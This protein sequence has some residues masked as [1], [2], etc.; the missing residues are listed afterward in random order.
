MDSKEGRLADNIV[1]FARVLRRAGLPIGPAKVIDAIEAV[2][3]V[4]VERRDDFRYALAAVLVNRREQQEIFDQAFEVYWRDPYRVERMLQE[5]LQ[6]MGGLRRVERD[7][8]RLAERV[9]RALAPQTVP[10]PR[11]REEPPPQAQPDARLTVSPRE[12]LQHKDFASMTPEELEEAKRVLRDMRLPLPMLPARRLESRARGRVDLRATMKQMIRQAGGVAELKR[13]APDERHP[14]LVVLC[15][16]SGSMESYTRMLLHFVHAVTNDRDRVHTFLFGT[17]LTNITRHLRNRDVDVALNAVSAAVHDWAGGTRIGACLK[18]FNQRWARRLLGQGAVV[19]LISDGLDSD[20]GEGLTREAA[21]LARSCR[22][23]IWLNPLLRYEGFE[24]RPAG[25]RAMLPYV[26][27][28]LPV[29]NLAS[30]TQL[31]ETLGNL[32]RPR[33]AG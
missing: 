8:P 27:A 11:A 17:R 1:H 19:L 9:A 3:A 21:R 24:A 14:T 15:D 5:L 25:I 26:D 28:F 23:L 2:Q 33:K 18:E 10:G 30:L 7:G 13:R 31:G 12:V 16:I 6:L 32:E 20:A 4:G 22:E 29:H